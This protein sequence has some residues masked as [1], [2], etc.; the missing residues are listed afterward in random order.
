MIYADN[1]LI[2]KAETIL[3][4]SNRLA[5][6]TEKKSKQKLESLKIQRANQKAPKSELIRPEDLV[7]KYKQQQQNYSAYKIKKRASTQSVALEVGKLIG[8]LRIRSSMNISPQQKRFL[9]KLGLRKQHE[10]GIFRVDEALIKELKLVEN[11][12]TYGELNRQTVRALLSKRGYL[13]NGKEL[14]P[15]KSNKVVEDILGEFGMVCI[16]DLVNEISFVA[17]NFEKVKEYL[18]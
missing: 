17:K 9:S 4:H 8:V 14:L 12:V 11:F 7:Y 5:E 10:L 3:R 18:W 13:K 6:L 16:D 15:V 2:Y 1:G